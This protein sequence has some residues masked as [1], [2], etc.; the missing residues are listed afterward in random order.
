MQNPQFHGTCWLG[1]RE[2]WSGARSK[3]GTIHSPPK[4]LLYIIIIILH[5]RYCSNFFCITCSDVYILLQHSPPLPSSPWPC[6]SYY[7]I[8]FRSIPPF[9]SFSVCV[10]THSQKYT[11]AKTHVR[12]KRGWGNCYSAQPEID[13]GFAP[14]A[15]MMSLY[16]ISCYP[17][18]PLLMHA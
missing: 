13:F 2:S 11:F 16:S 14:G 12:E 8:P 9:N 1:D 6:Y 10:P 3:A 7:F 5:Y 18:I 17:S 15:D 4:R